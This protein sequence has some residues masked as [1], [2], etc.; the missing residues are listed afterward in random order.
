MVELRSRRLVACSTIPAACKPA[1]TSKAADLDISLTFPS[2]KLFVAP[3]WH[4][5]STG[6]FFK[7]LK[8]AVLHIGGCLDGGDRLL[9]CQGPGAAAAGLLQRVHQQQ[10][11]GDRGR[12]RH[13]RH[14]TRVPA[15]PRLPALHFPLLIRF[16]LAPLLSVG[17]CRDTDECWW[18]GL[19]VQEQAR[20]AC[21]LIALAGTLALAPSQCRGA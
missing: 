17:G 21:P 8:K 5:T 10:H 9:Q 7:R 14:Q 18:K 11:A 20:N 1:S 15:Q 3:R 13:P 19:W 16:G 2:N 6:S 4:A 12:E